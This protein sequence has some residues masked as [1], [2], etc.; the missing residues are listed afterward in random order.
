MKSGVLCIVAIF[1]GLVTTGCWAP[2]HS[3]SHVIPACQLPDEFRTSQRVVGPNLNYASLTLPP[4]AEFRLGPGDELEFVIPDLFPGRETQMFLVRVTASG[5]IQLPLIAPV[6]VQDLTVTEVHRAVTDAYSE[7]ILREPRVNVSLS[8]AS[9]VEVLVLGEVNDPGTKILPRY[10]NDVGHALAAAGGFS[11]LA[12]DMIEVHRR[13]PFPL[14]GMGVLAIEEG[15][16]IPTHLQTLS[17]PANDPKS[18]TQIPLR[19]LPSDLLE[20]NDVLL[21]PGDVVV[22]P[23]RQNEVFWVVGEL[24]DNNAVRFTVGIR[25]RELGAGLLLPPDREIDVVTAVVMAGYIDPID[26]PTTVTLQRIMPDGQSLLVHVDLIKARYDRRET[27]LVE[28]GDIIYL[29]PDAPWWCRRTFDR[30]L[31]DLI[32]LPYGLGLSRGILGPRVRN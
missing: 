28:T 12:A 16:M 19:G 8:M 13:I 32:T 7:G 11:E 4:P 18:I 15:T 23:T 22:V 17:G 30:V 9:T 29:N 26:S 27:I 14:N 1:L 6:K 31:P 21:G 20:P 3:R 2:L 25:E 5:D 10:Q 24:N